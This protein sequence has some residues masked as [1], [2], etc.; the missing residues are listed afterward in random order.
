MRYFVYP[1]PNEEPKQTRKT[2]KTINVVKKTDWFSRFFFT[3]VSTIQTTKQRIQEKY[4][5]CGAPWHLPVAELSTNPYRFISKNPLI[6]L[7]EILL[8]SK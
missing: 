2:R 3:L 7:Q 1:V 4:F 6:F 5:L 8:T